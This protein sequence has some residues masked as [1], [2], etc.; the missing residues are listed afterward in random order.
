MGFLAV[1]LW[2]VAHEV[3]HIGLAALL[4]EGKRLEPKLKGLN[5]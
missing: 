3:W 2:D 1:S 4:K 5:S